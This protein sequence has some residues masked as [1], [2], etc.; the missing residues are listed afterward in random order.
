[1][2]TAC[3]VSV[4]TGLVHFQLY[5]KHITTEKCY[6]GLFSERSTTSIIRE[7]SITPIAKSIMCID[8]EK[9]VVTKE[10][11]DK[12]CH[13]KMAKKRS[14]SWYRKTGNGIRLSM[15]HFRSRDKRSQWREYATEFENLLL[16]G[17]QLDMRLKAAKEAEKNMEQEMEGASNYDCEIQNYY[18][19]E[20]KRYHEDKEQNDRYRILEDI[21]F[22]EFGDELNKQIAD[23]ADEANQQRL[24]EEMRKHAA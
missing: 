5:D 4:D 20:M 22:K 11:W 17:Y 6:N 2:I 3:C 16:A 9:V 8:E 15:K 18:E 14:K 21:M 19:R 13:R 12:D 1:M 23:E 7:S 24:D 10:R